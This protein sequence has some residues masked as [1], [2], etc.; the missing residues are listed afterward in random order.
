MPRRILTLILLASATALAGCGGERSPADYDARI[1]PGERAEGAR[2]H[3]QLLAEF[4][5]SY[6]S[7]EARYVA[8]VGEK[9]AEAAGLE[10]QCTFTLVNTDVV[11]AFAVPGCFIYITRGLMG[12]VNS[13]AQLASVLGHEVGH[14]V[15]DH[16]QRQQRR[17][18]LTGL[19]ALAVGLLTGSERLAQF[20]GRA[21]ELFTLRYSRDQEFES[22]TLGIHYTRQ[23]GYDPYEAAEMLDA[24]ARNEA[25]LARTRGDDAKSIPGW[26]RTHPLTEE[27]IARATATAKRT[28]V[29][30]TDLPE[31]EVPFL[32]EVDGL[33]YGDDPIQGYVHGRRFSH[34]DMRISF[35]APPGFT[36]TNTPRAVLID[37]RDGTRGEFGGGPM[38]PGGLEAYAV[39]L[40]EQAVGDARGAVQAG[41]LQRRLIGGVPAVILPVSIRTE[42]GSAQLVVAAYGAGRG[43]YH[44]LMVAPPT[45]AAQAAIIELFQSFRP[46]SP[47]QV[48]QLRPRVIDVVAARPGDT[49]RN[50]AARMAVPSLPLEHFLMINDRQPDQPIAPGELVKIV[51]Y[52]GR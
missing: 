37:G 7:P 20:A 4:G 49:V 31:G 17:S 6:D 40:V 51:T 30:E 26:A 21:A 25:L 23:A 50:F 11:N 34:P 42:Q 45:E 9:I 44:F 18:I 10:G 12:I 28:G 41:E 22:D 24:L 15:A 38:P 39:R 3:P 52:A 29:T 5:G 1:D 36:L 35:E 16:S 2:Q 8:A 47:A 48:A 33:L 46:L 19:G 14:I 27:R 13:E 43:A 32:R